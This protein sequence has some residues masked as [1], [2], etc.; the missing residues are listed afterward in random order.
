MFSIDYGEDL[1]TIVD[2]F[3]S[4]A[5]SAGGTEGTSVRFNLD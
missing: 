1:F 2:L 5:R 4:E 3:M